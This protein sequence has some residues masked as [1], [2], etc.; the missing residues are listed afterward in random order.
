MANRNGYFQLDIGDD[1]TCVKLFPPIDG[2]EPISLEEL[3]DYLVSKGLNPDVVLL[4]HELEHLTAP[5]LV[6]V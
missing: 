2:G 5:K 4:K 6:M 3:R 1:C